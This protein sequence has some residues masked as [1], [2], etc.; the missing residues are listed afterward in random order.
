MIELLMIS[1]VSLLL[2]MDIFTILKDSM[3][4]IHGTLNTHRFGT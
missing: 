2:K 1:S 3:I 4:R